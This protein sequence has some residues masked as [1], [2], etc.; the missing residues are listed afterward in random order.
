MQETRSGRGGKGN[1]SSGGKRA[2]PIRRFPPEVL[3]PVEIAALM[4]ACGESVTGMRNRALIAVLHRS[5]LRV[6]EALALY[7]KDIDFERCAIRV[8]FGKGGRSRTVGID[9]GALAHL[10]AWLDARSKAGLDRT[11]PVF[12]VVHGPAW[13]DALEPGFVRLAFKRLAVRAGLAKR[14]HPHGLRHTH[15]SELR[16]EGFDIGIISK[17]LGH[18]DISTTARYLDHVAPWSVVEAVRNRTGYL[19]HCIHI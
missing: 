6:S 13:G 8:L 7:E 11:W 19:S 5:G 1:K 2:K 18:R 16:Q 12:C 9:P 3:T 17:Q 4:A 10:R 15:A 14:V